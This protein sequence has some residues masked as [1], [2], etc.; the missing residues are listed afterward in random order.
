MPTYNIKN[1]KTGEV[2]ELFCSYDDKVK[3]LKNNPDWEYVIAAPEIAYLGKSAIARTDSG[4]K[5]HLTRI[6]DAAGK[7]RSWRKKTINTG[8]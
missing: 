4:W 2:K 3:Y 6:S 7:S 8:R 5:D 1:K